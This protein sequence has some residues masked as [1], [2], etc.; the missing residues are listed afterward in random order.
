M[1]R[2]N[3]Q[4]K[5]GVATL[6]CKGRIVFGLEV[7]TLRSIAKTR[8]EQFLDVDLSEVET[9]DAT[10]LGLLVE[11]QYWSLHEG[12]MLR[13]VNAS[14]FV[15]KLIVMTRLNCVLAMP[16]RNGFD[17]FDT[18]EHTQRAAMIA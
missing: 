6:Y 11:L 9:L 10:G 15:W 7:E 18:T 2:I 1:L 14:E 8:S 4:S 17:C 5:N 16:A 13:F 3:I 12:R